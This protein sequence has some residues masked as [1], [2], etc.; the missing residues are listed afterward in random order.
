MNKPNPIP[1]GYH[2]VTPVIS[3]KDAAALI[4]FME[5]VLDA[6]R[7]EYITRP[8]GAIMHAEVRIG[9]SKV[10]IGEACDGMGPTPGA[11][12]L[13]LDDCD[14]FFRRAVDAGATVIMEPTDMFWGDRYSCVRDRWGNQ[15]SFATHIEDVSKDEIDRRA[16]EFMENAGKQ[17]VQ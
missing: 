10:M 8:D 9:D 11:L 5:Q 2:T 13:Y 6:K 3:V 1:S 15:W 14:E 7:A 17:H 12:F 4:D 16:R